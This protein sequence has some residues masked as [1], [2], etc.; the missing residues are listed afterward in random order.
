MA[1]AP[2]CKKTA[3][4]TRKHNAPILKETQEL[5]D[6]TIDKM[7]TAFAAIVAGA[8]GAGPLVP[9]WHGDHETERV[10]FAGKTPRDVLGK[11][12][13]LKFERFGP[14]HAR[15]V[16][17]SLRLFASP[18]QTVK[19]C[20]VHPYPP[21]LLPE[22]SNRAEIDTTDESADRCMLKTGRPFRQGK[23]S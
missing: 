2:Q 19:E 8:F 16:V 6:P 3:E 9:S 10:S 20:C 11:E 22:Y 5:K 13:P 7:I 17:E 4:Q 12:L 18:L 14:Q 23:N 21:S 1:K 15:D